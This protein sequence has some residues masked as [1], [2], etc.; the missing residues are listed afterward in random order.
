[1]I[2]CFI[3]VII[4]VIIIIIIIIIIV[5]ITID[6]IIIIIMIIINF[7]VVII[8]IMLIMVIT[9]TILIHIIT[10]FTGHQQAVN[11]IAFSPDARFLASASFDKKVKLWCGKTGRFLATLSSHVGS[12]KN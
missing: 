3:I 5:I 11:H 1:M 6:M 10:F 7:I 2:S 4:T 12:G 9:L 8:L